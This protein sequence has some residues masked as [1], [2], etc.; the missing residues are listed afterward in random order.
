MTDRKETHTASVLSC[1][2]LCQVRIYREQREGRKMRIA[3]Y[4]QWLKKRSDRQ[5]DIDK[6]L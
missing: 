1:I 4:T 2:V 6:R 3:V 5:L